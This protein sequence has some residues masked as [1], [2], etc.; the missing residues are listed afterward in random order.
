MEGEDYWQVFNDFLDI[1]NFI[2]IGLQT[3]NFYEEK[4]KSPVKKEKNKKKQP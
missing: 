3:P 1:K 2:M 4:F